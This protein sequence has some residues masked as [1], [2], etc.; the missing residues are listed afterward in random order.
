M[1]RQAR[2]LPEPDFLQS[3]GEAAAN[4]TAGTERLGISVVDQSKLEGVISAQSPHSRVGPS[5]GGV[6]QKVAVGA[7][8]GS[9]CVVRERAQWGITGGSPRGP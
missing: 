3:L 9:I 1:G 7:K 8:V 2:A 6:R 5:M 4:L